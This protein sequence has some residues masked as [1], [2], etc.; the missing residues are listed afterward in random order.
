MRR[1]ATWLLIGA[2]AALGLAAAVDALRG[3]DE[4]VVAERSTST[5]SGLAEEPELA[6]R[7][8][9]EAGVQ[10]VLTYSDDDCRLHAVSLPDLEPVRAP[11]FQMCRPLTDS[12]GLGVSD[13]N[14]VW[15]GLGLG[16]IQE[17]I[18][19]EELSRDLR[20][21]LAI[22][23]DAAAEFR[24]AQAVS[25]G[26]ERY[27]VLAEQTESDDR[28]VA[29]FDGN[30]PVFVHPGWRVGGA[31]FVRPSPQ[32]RFYAL[33]GRGPVGER[34][35]DRNGH[36]VGVP[37]GIAGATA[38]AWS[39][40]DRWTAVVTP[41]SIYVFPSDRAQKPVVRIPLTV[42]DLDWTTEPVAAVNP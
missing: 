18:S 14:V 28:V 11:S 8:L 6:V 39:P 32:G 2:V 37:A 24:A 13:G 7:Q 21:A 23:D 17:V 40:D 3:D 27:V 26:D 41:A 19:R 15:A 33:L 31:R 12:G 16:V 20:R 10:G 36:G 34:I 22:P 9:R 29:G 25:L 1:I 42:Q 35:Y 38:V 30:R 4:V 5:I